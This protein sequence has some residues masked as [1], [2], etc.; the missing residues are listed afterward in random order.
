[1]T[2]FNEKHELERRNQAWEKLDGPQRDVV[3]Q[4]LIGATERCMSHTVLLLGDS[5][6]DSNKEEKE[7]VRGT[8]V[9]VK[10]GHKQGIL[11]AAHVVNEIKNLKSSDSGDFAIGMLG[12]G[13]RVVQVNLQAVEIKSAGLQNNQEHGPDIAWI[14]ISPVDMRRIESQAG[15]FYNLEK[16]SVQ[17]LGQTQEGEHVARTLIILGYNAQRTACAKAA[18]YNASVVLPTQINDIEW[19]SKHSDSN[20]WDYGE[21]ELYDPAEPELGSIIKQYNKGAHSEALSQVIGRGGLNEPTDWGGA[22]GSGIWRLNVKTEENKV[23]V[24]LEGV[25]YYQITDKSQHPTSKSPAVIRAHGPMSL[26]KLQ[27]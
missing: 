16:D 15:V 27:C 13:G 22:S 1:M 4:G 19:E 10:T 2:I 11:T 25:A 7:L 5:K 24:E 8:G 23:W 12:F 26:K 20:E 21:C 14:G 3:R 17:R 9:L 6:P 18:G